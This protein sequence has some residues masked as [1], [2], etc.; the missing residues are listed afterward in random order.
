MIFLMIEELF[1]DI[2]T[3]PT[4]FYRNIILWCVINLRVESGGGG[5]KFDPTPRRY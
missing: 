3:T 4:I 1:V 5:R 2:L